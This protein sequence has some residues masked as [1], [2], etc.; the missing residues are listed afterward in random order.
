MSVVARS[1]AKVADCSRGSCVTAVGEPAEH[2]VKGGCL[3][4]EV[5]KEPRWVWVE[6]ARRIGECVRLLLDSRSGLPLPAAVFARS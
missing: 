1:F 3:P 4:S 5:V 6:P 2:D